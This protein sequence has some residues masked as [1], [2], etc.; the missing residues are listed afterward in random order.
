[1]NFFLLILGYVGALFVRESMPLASGGA[2]AGALSIVPLAI[3]WFTLVRMRLV[4]RIWAALIMGVVV[5]SV[6]FF[7][8]GTMIVLFVTLALAV[9]MP[10][11]LLPG[12]LFIPR[13]AP[14]FALTLILLIVGA[15]W[16]A[17]LVAAARG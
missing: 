7:P 8:G 17:L 6:S 4:P 10:L 9:E 15:P 5:D 16:F 2:V 11:R 1:M 13:W 14:V 3:I 12:L